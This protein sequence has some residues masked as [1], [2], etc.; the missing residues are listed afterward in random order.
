MFAGSMLTRPR[1][2]QHPYAEWGKNSKKLEPREDF[3]SMLFVKD[4]L[5]SPKFVR[6]F[7]IN[8]LFITDNKVH[9]PRRK[10]RVLYAA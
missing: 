9:L 8:S 4:V 3:N 10:R 2:T 1:C 7:D 5:P 6:H